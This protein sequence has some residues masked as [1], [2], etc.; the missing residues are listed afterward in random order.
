MPARHVALDRKARRALMLVGVMLLLMVALAV[1][2]YVARITDQGAP[3]VPASM[4][5]RLVVID[6]RTLIVQPQDL[7]RT[8][9]N[10]L[11]SGN[12]KS[13]SFEFGDRSFQP[14]SAEPSQITVVRVKQ[15]AGV[16]EADPNL[17]VHILEPRYHASPASGKLD[18]QRAARFRDA[19]VSSGVNAS[20]VTIEEK[21]SNLPFA[22][23]PY[24]V[25]LLSKE[26]SR[27]S[28]S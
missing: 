2:S 27:S 23:S 10:W 28:S 15:V 18:D 7:G 1:W 25:V 22:R 8:M 26:R 5:E 11:K 3:A 21:S 9:T 13:L 4:D 20:R 16:A 12:E 19:L 17:T 6:K 24:T 14:N